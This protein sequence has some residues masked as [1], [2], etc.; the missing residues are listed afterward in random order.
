MALGAVVYLNR[1]GHIDIYIP[2]KLRPYCVK[3]QAIA[4]AA[5][6]D[7]HKKQLNEKVGDSNTLAYR[8]RIDPTKNGFVIDDDDLFVDE[9]LLAE[10]K[11]TD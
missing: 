2:K 10:K 4:E 11:H 5:H 9:Q 3:D 8:L 7:N 6:A 1:E